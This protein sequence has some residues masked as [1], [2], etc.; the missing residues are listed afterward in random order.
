MVEFVKAVRYVVS[1]ESS[2]VPSLKERWCYSTRLHY[3][4]LSKAD[5]PAKYLEDEDILALHAPKALWSPTCPRAGR[6]CQ[7]TAISS[8]SDCRWK[9]TYMAIVMLWLLLS[10]ERELRSKPGRP[11]DCARQNQAQLQGPN[12]NPKIIR[13]PS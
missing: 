9:L 2:G 7:G 13:P 11:V 1:D 4:H 3:Y 6:G 12:G 5:L 10:A 8:L